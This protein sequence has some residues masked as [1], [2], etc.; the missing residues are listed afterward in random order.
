MWYFL[1]RLAMAPTLDLMYPSFKI[2]YLQ[3]H[4]LKGRFVHKMDLLY[5]LSQYHANIMLSHLTIY[6]C[7][8]SH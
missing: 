6:T 3:K 2:Q 5:P 4:S 1:E 7:N 8:I